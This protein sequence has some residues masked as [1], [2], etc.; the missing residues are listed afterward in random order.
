MGHSRK[1]I[2]SKGRLRWVACYDDARGRRRSA[3]TFERRKDSDHAW[4]EAEALQR[5]G[6]PG[7]P[8]AGRITFADYAVKQWLPHHVMEPTTREGYEYYIH[9]H[10]IPWFGQMRMSD[11]LPTHVREWVSDMST[12][13]MTPA[14][15]RHVKIILSAIFTTALNDYVVVIHAGRG[16]KSPTV[17]IKEYRI[18]TPDEYSQLCRALPGDTARLF[19]ETDIGSGLRWGELAELRPRDLNATSEILTVSQ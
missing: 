12:A 7:D 9:R 15:I 3:G 5:T 14:T 2:D 18:V 10:L 17:P 4:Q 8:R 16:V 13:G 19:V 6:R 1:R 11:I